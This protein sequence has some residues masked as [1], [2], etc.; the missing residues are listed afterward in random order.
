M[1][2]IFSDRRLDLYLF[3]I[4]N[5][6]LTEEPYKASVLWPRKP[7]ILANLTLVS[8]LIHYIS[9]H[10]KA[11]LIRAWEIKLMVAL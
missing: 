11:L 2:G 5:A 3:L 9:L 8:L 1:V 4:L 6:S 10:S 7:S